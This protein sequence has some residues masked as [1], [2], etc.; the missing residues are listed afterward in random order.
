MLCSRGL[1]QEGGKG[2][3]LD[4]RPGKKYVY[5][6]RDGPFRARTIAYVIPYRDKYL[7]LEFQ[8]DRELYAVQLHILA[9]FTLT[10]SSLV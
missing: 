5:D 1:R 6:H 10:R 8:T 4:G 2:I 9:S 7:G 3:E